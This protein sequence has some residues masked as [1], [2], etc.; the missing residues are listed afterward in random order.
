MEY[1]TG[2]RLDAILENQEKQLKALEYI[3]TA[4]S[5]NDLKPK[6]VKKNESKS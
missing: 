5:D 3:M 6:E 2:V 1:D 4:L